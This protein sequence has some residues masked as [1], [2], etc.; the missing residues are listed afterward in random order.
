MNDIVDR[1]MRDFNRY[2]GDGLPN[3]PVG[4]PL[5]IGDPESGPFIPKK[6]QLREWA[7]DIEISAAAGT[8]LSANLADESQARIAGDD[9]HSEGA[10]F[11]GAFD[12]ASGSFPSSREQG[13]AVQNGD[14]F[15]VPDGLAGTVD[16]TAFLVRQ[17]IR[18]LVD[19]PSTTTFS[20]NWFVAATDSNLSPVYAALAERALDYGPRNAA[21]AAKLAAQPNGTIGW[22]GGLQYQVDSSATGTS[23]ATND[24]GVDGLVPFGKV[25]LLHY[26]VTGTGAD[27]SAGINAALSAGHK[28]VVG[29]PDV[30]YRADGEIEIHKDT[31]LRDIHITAA[32]SSGSFPNNA[33][34]SKHG[35]V[36]TAL[37]TLAGNV[38]RGASTI[39]F[40]A[41]HGLSA[42]DMF[43]LYDANDYSLFKD[44]ALPVAD[45]QRDY[46]KDGEKCVVGGVLSATEVQILSPLYSDYL[47]A[48]ITCLNASDYGTGNMDNV[49]VIAPNNAANGDVQGLHIKR[50]RNMH[51]DNLDISGGGSVSFSTILLFDSTV[52]NSRFNQWGDDFGTNLRYGWVY[53]NC[54]DIKSTGCAFFGYRHG[55]TG[56]GGPEVSIPCR[57]VNISE[58]SATNI[59]PGIAA[60]DWHGN[61]LNCSYTDGVL[62]GGGFNIA[63]NG[64]TVSNIEINGNEDCIVGLGRE[65]LGCDHVIENVRGFSGRN[66]ATRGIID[67]GGNSLALTESTR[68]GGAF[69]FKDANIDAPNQERSSINIRNRGATVDFDVIVDGGSYIA[70]TSNNASFGVLALGTVSGNHPQRAQVTG[71]RTLSSTATPPI[72]SVNPAVA[73]RLDAQQGV[74]VVSTGTGTSA[75]TGVVNFAY[76][77]PRVPVFKHSLSA[78]STSLVSGVPQDAISSEDS[79]LSA[80]DM[81]VLIRRIDKAGGTAGEQNFEADIPVTVSWTASIW[82]W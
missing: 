12:A 32:G 43:I 70:P 51:L 34:M 60:A 58:F 71:V 53:A 25:Q 64:N 59:V 8:N 69:V 29:N 7:A 35:G 38:T 42:G 36:E 21:N 66:D 56:G 28:L 74:V 81:R 54:Q 15:E 49:S 23:S 68:F 17:R 48:N 78:N 18:A 4:H 16:G 62:N 50:C 72:T 76:S 1:N 2:T 11:G 47:A 20:G 77:F 40:A 57:A 14:Y 3:E 9:A 39:T 73:L 55:V 63:G 41:A 44:T 26:G 33:V 31:S 37:P 75:N 30:V 65:I 6:E 45:R 27:E 79:I 82:E 5:P 13:G 46:Y 10:Y 19:N 80:T 22:L 24:L 61:C 52:T 67:I